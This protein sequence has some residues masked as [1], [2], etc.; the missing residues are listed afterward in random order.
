[1]VKKK[2][3][4]QTIAIIILAILLLLTIGFGGVYAFYTARTNKVSGTIVMANLKIALN[5]NGSGDSSKTDIVI[6]NGVNVV[7]G[8]KLTNSP[9]TISNYSSVPVYL[10]VVYELNATV[11]DAKL[12][13][14]VPVEDTYVRPVLGLGYQY[15]NDANE[16]NPGTSA[17]DVAWVDYVFDAN[18]V[19]NGEDKIYRCLALTAPLAEL[20]ARESADVD[21]VAPVATVIKENSLALHFA[22]GNEY[23]NATIH[24]TFQAFAIAS[25]SFQFESGTSKADK[26]RTIVRAIYASQDCKFFSI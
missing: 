17:S 5:A 23:Q 9:L 6:S 7:P 4:G 10:L 13:Q 3:S 2:L 26:C 21:P 25:S 11:Y 19:E 18:D 22:M 1:M 24:M 15:V 20:P 8:Q 12:E 16:F 14:D